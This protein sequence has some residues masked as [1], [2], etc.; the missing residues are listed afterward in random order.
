MYLRSPPPG[1]STLS[2]SPVQIGLM[3]KNAKCCILAKNN[4]EH[5]YV[6]NDHVL[7]MSEQQK[8][9]DIVVNNNFI[10]HAH[11]VATAKKAKQVL[12]VIKKSY[13]TRNPHSSKT[14]YAAMVRPHL[15]YGNAVWGP[16]YSGDFKMFEKFQ[17]RATKMV[18]T[19]NDLPY[20]KRLRA[21]KLP[22][23]VY[24]H[25]R[26]DD[27]NVQDHERIDGDK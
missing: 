16:T 2:N 5:H 8:D 19:I 3:L 18:T 11:A 6:L 22:T 9:L 21:L 23:L 14:L 12:G 4:P 15:G 10:F 20:E 17:R 24:R 13:N 27:S 25:R 1:H 26:R 7:E